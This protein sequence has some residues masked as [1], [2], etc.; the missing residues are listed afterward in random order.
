MS[1][2][3]DSVVS[4]ADALPLQAPTPFDIAA[5]TD[6][7]IRSS[8]GV[9]FHVHQLL[10]AVSSGFFES[11][12]T[13]PQNCSQ[14]AQS[15]EIPTVDV[16][17]TSE[18]LGNIFPFIDPRA[19]K[20]SSLSTQQ[21]I[22]IFETLDKYQMDNIRPY[23]APYLQKL[24]QQEPVR[25]FLLAAETA[26]YEEWASSVARMAAQE[27]LKHH[28]DTLLGSVPLKGPQTV[29]TDHVHRLLQYHRLCGTLAQKVVGS[30]SDRL[31]QLDIEIISSTERCGCNLTQDEVMWESQDH[32]MSYAA[33]WWEDVAAALQEIICLHPRYLHLDLDN[34]VSHLRLRKN[35]TCMKRQILKGTPQ[36]VAFCGQMKLRV[37]SIIEEVRTQCSS[38]FQRLNT[39]AG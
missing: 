32:H 1:E 38:I 31:E 10:M 11:M 18:V 37:E 8:D 6:L 7:I 17:E 23:F 27:T 28:L 24:V 5:S 15:T 36:I 20:P 21:L 30:Q 9:E 26:A 19:K 39:I 12:F 33:H 34:F 13:L 35:G 14:E 25:M 4:Q 22:S 3:D 2:I 29:S 16:S